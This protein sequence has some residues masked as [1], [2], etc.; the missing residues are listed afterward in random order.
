MEDLLTRPAPAPAGTFLPSAG[1]HPL[2]PDALLVLPQATPPAPPGRLRQ[3]WRS[4]PDGVAAGRGSDAAV[5]GALMVL[6]L[7]LHW[8]SLWASYWGDE[9][10]AIGIA[11]HPLSALPHYLVDDG[12]PPLYYVMLH[13]WMLLFG[14]SEVATHSLSMIPGL[15]AVPAAWWSGHRLFGR[16]AARAAAALVATCA[17]LDYYSTETRMYSWLALVAILAVTCFVLAFRG[18]GRRYWV[19]ATLLMACVLC[20]QYYGLYLLAATVIAG[21]VSSWYAGRPATLRATWIYGA[22]CAALFSP[23]VPQFLYQ[24]HNAG[25]RGRPT[26][27]CSTSSATPSMLWPRPPGPPS[28]SSWLSPSC[29]AGAPTVARRRTGA[30]TGTRARAPGRQH[31]PGLVRP[32]LGHGR[33][34]AHLGAGLAGRS[35]HQFLEPPLPR[36]CR[37]ARAHPPGRR[38]GPLPAEVLGAVGDGRRPGRHQRPHVG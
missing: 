11:A 15:L 27:P 23:W 21:S 34:S 30:T 17:Y 24:L 28:L 26:R 3:W 9:A 29:A 7:F 16:W 33:T 20:L 12:S 4:Q 5:V 31:G 19:A 10:I 6:A 36:D 35:S 25:A 2:G 38:A 1:E 37:G 8:R 14:R 32:G 13:Y 22:A 18:A